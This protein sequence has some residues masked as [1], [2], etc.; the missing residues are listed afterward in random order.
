[1]RA[2][3]SSSLVPGLG[4]CTSLVPGLGGC[5]SLVPGLGGSTSLVPGLGGMQLHSPGTRGVPGLAVH[6]IQ[7]YPSPRTAGY[8]YHIVPGLWVVPGLAA[9]DGLIP[10]G[11]T[12]RDSL[13]DC[14]GARNWLRWTDFK[15]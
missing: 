14:F 15:S 11:R 8:L 12:S 1:M 9:T 3:P 13:R 5:T 4:G 10:R 7:K 6:N 2:P